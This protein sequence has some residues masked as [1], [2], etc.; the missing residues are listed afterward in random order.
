MPAPMKPS[1]TGLRSIPL[2]SL[3]C[4]RAVRVAATVAARREDFSRNCLRLREWLPDM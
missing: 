4:A 2:A 3:T 1:L